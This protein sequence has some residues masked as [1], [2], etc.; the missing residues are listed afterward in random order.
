MNV[1]QIISYDLIPD[2]NKMK[3]IVYEFHAQIITLFFL[4]LFF[5]SFFQNCLIKH[6]ENG[7]SAI[8]GDFGLAE[9]IPDHRYMN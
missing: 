2:L 8:V 9:K 6:D 1:L 5:Y 4:L 3:Q 7:Y